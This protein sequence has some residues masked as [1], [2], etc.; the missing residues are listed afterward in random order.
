[1]YN[2][3]VPFTYTPEVREQLLRHGLSP[4]DHTDPRFVRAYLSQ[5]YRF[6]IRRLKR[7]LLRREFPQTEYIGRVRALRREYVL[8][9]IPIETWTTASG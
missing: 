9:S 2:P 4:A 5:L 3:H 1:M 8:L 6:E 7:R